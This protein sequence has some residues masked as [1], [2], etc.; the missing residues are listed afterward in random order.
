MVEATCFS[1]TTI[2][3]QRTT[4]RYIPEDRNLHNHRGENLRSYIMQGRLLLRKLA[5]NVEICFEVRHDRD[6]PD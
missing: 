4:R 3:S 5:Q 6:W 1:E 2:D